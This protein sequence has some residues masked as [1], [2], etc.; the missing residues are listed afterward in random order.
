MSDLLPKIERE[1]VACSELLAA[2]GRMAILWR[3]A[4]KR[5][6]LIKIGLLKGGEANAELALEKQLH[7]LRIA[8]DRY[9]AANNVL[10]DTASDIN[11]P[12]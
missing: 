4:E 10:G 1:A 12:K 3:K 6:A 5:H 9:E 7:Q 11:K 2:V 8:S